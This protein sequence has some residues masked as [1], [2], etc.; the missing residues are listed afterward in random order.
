M[1]RLDLC[2]PSV[3]LRKCPL[4]HQPQLGLLL[5]YCSRFLERLFRLLAPSGHYRSAR[6]VRSDPE[7][8][9]DQ[10]GRVVVADHQPAAV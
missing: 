3:L 8:Q 5:L 6:E 7:D 9:P 10:P 2:R 1:R 4:I